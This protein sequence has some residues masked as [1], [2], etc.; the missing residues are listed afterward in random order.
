[1]GLKKL[2]GQTPT[3]P[4]G[5]EATVTSLAVNLTV[6]PEAPLLANPADTDD[7][8]ACQDAFQLIMQDF[9]TTTHTFSDE[10]QEACKEVQTIVRK[11]LRKSTTIG[12]TFVWGALAAIRRWVKAVHLAMDCMG[13]SIEEQTRLLQ[14]ARQ[15]R[16]E[17]TEDILALLPAEESPYL[18]PVVPREDILT[19]AL[20]ATRKHTEKAIE[21]VNVQLP[22]LVHRHI[23]PQQAGVFLASLLQVMCSYQQE[24]DGMATGQ[25]VLLS[26][27]VPN[28]WG[29]QLEHDGGSHPAGSPRLP[30]KLASFFGRAGVCRS[31]Q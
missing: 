14:E 7:E 25:V 10:Y 2:W 18:T 19:P 21:A 29:G 23:P 4:T 17:A 26:Q 5:Q 1:M 31:H 15:A 28:L 16:K 30:C 8:K 22:A 11:S 13:E 3:G 9:H 12:R 24:M 27:I 6:A 20:T